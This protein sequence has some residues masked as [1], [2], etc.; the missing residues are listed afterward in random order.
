MGWEKRKQ[1]ET[2]KRGQG[3]KGERGRDPGRSLETPSAGLGSSLW[4]QVM[5]LGR[6]HGFGGYGG[7]VVPPGE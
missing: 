1:V 4:F 5:P 2:W 7:A 6:P 3:N